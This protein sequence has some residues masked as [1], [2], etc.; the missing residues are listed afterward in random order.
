MKKIVSLFIISIFMMGNY[1]SAQNWSR[2]I[3]GA[4]KAYQAY[5]LS[6]EEIQNYVHE[7]ITGLDAQSTVCGANDPYTLRLNKLTKGLTDVDGLPLNFKVYKT[8]EVNA[9]ACADGSVRV[10]SG[11]MDLM[12]DDEILGVI[13]HEV[14]HVAHKDTKE[15]FKNALKTS[16]LMD[17][18]ASTSTKV[19]ALTDS[20]IGAIGEKMLNARYSRKQEDNADDYG[21]DYLK[22]SGKNP[23]AM[24]MAFEKLQTLE[25]AG[26]STSSF[27]K[28]LFSD[29]PETAKRIARME[30]RAKKDGYSRPSAN[31]TTTAKTSTTTKKTT[32]KKTTTTKKKTTTTKKK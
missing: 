22:K 24:T 19:A 15:A 7:Y 27:V 4:Q 1:A 11:L 5:K 9:F 18:L 6:D 32:T 16:A 14:G 12:T 10:Y 29:H 30:E 31:A 2:I 23:Y 25:N 26:G 13:G 28:N 20:Q 8:T 21:Y 17:G 3:S